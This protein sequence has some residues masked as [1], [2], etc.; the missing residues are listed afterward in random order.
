MFG[1]GASARWRPRNNK[2]TKARQGQVKAVVTPQ[3]FSMAGY[4]G[5]IS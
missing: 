4:I 2:K 5:L 3:R 1:G